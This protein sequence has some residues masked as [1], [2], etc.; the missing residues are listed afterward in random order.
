MRWSEALTPPVF[1]WGTYH[2]IRSSRLLSVMSAEREVEAATVCA[3]WL[4]NGVGARDWLARRD[5]S[6]GIDQWRRSFTDGPP[7][8]SPW[9]EVLCVGHPGI[10]ASTATATAQ[11]D[12]SQRYLIPA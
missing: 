12:P 8:L 7:T 3:V 6:G 9:A 1:I 2:T 10:V 4:C 11:H 5:V